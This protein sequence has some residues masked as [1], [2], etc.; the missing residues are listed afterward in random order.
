MKQFWS[1]MLELARALCERGQMLVTVE[2][3]AGGL[4]GAACTAVAGSS[5]WFERSLVTYS[6]AA[7]SEMLGVD[8]A[9]I[10]AHGAVSREVA[11]AMAEGALRES[12]ADIAFSIT[13]FAGPGGPDD[14]P[15]LVHFGC[16]RTG[17]PTRH[18]EE[19]FGDIGRGP[20][21][22]KCMRVALQMLDEA[23]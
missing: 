19:H 18:R 6:N 16:A 2:S 10:A 21:R 22:V 20:V 3:C 11:V 23:L 9:L 17:R 14:E 1:A 4:I 7:K 15:G 12:H 8:P 13:G 5:D